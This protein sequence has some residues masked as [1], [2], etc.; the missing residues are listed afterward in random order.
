M[1][2]NTQWRMKVN[3]LLKISSI[4]IGMKRRIDSIVDSISDKIILAMILAFF[5]LEAVALGV[6]LYELFIIATVLL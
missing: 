3:T 2:L 6:F 4:I 5:L 1:C